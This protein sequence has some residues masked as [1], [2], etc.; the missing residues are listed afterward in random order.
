MA[1]QSRFSG[2]EIDEVI[3]YCRTGENL[4]YLNELGSRIPLIESNAAN[5]A[6]LNSTVH[7]L[8]QSFDN[9]VMLLTGGQ[10]QEGTTAGGHVTGGQITKSV[11]CNFFEA[12]NNSMLKITSPPSTYAPLYSYQLTDGDISCGVVPID[13]QNHKIVWKYTPNESYENKKNDNITELASIT[14]LGQVFGAVWN[15][16]AEYRVS[17]ENESGRVVC[18]NG[19]GT[20]SRSYKRLQPGACVISDTYG[21][22]IGETEIAKCPIAVS[23]RVLA[24]PYE[25]WWTFEPGEPVCAG[26]NGTVSKMTRREVKKYPERII[27]TVSEL[28][29]YETWGQDN[30]KVNGRIWIRIK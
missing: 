24:Y 1:Y 28:P 8:N 20:L 13:N 29:T 6:Q 9:K 19:D 26:P 10:L 30:T 5:I 25:D 17:D 16:Y 23:G 27:G 21:F 4:R 22:A 7:D 3:T 11:N 2:A 12:R 14:T 18:E 15:D